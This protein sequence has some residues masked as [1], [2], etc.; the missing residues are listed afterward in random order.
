VLRL[1]AVTQFKR[2]LKRF[3]NDKKIQEKLEEII[4]LLVNEKKLP[5]ITLRKR[6]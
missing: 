3:K 6:S 5:K 1:K 2:D 4:D